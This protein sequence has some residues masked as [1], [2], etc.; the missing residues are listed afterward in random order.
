MQL[1]P[2]ASRRAARPSELAQALRAAALGLCLGPIGF[3]ASAQA[4]TS[5]Q[6]SRQRHFE[7]APGPLG[8]ALAEFASQAG[9]TLPL[10]PQRVQGLRSRGLSGDADVDTGLSRLLEGT[11][12]RASRQG[13]GLYVL[14]PVAEAEQPLKMDSSE[15]MGVRQDGLTEGT[16]SYTTGAMQTATKLNLSLR[17]TP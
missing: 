9:I 7:I 17:E 8:A 16:G 2:F 5:D 3:V 11:G 4:D 12:L 15:I 10:Q 14:R 6:A 13:D 1:H